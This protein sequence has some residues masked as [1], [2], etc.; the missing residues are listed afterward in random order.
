[1]AGRK[2]NFYRSDTDDL[3]DDSYA[4]YIYDVWM[5]YDDNAEQSGSD[6]EA[7]CDFV[8]SLTRLYDRFDISVIGYEQCY[9][10]NYIRNQKDPDNPDEYVL[11][12]HD[13]TLMNC[14]VIPVTADSLEAMQRDIM[15]AVMK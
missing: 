10:M 15:R 4:N 13:G 2:I 6:Y 11:I 7:K 14:T 5:A 3:Y 9:M 8:R 12:W 1:M